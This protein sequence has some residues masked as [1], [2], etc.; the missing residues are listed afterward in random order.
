MVVHSDETS[1]R[2]GE[3]RGQIWVTRL[4]E[5]AYHQD[6]IDIRYRG[7]TE[8]MFWGCYTSEM[9]GPSFMFT[10]ESAPERHH[11]QEDLNSRNSEY[12]VQQQI[13]QEHFLAEQARKPPSRRL[14]RVPKPEGVLLE[15]NKN[16]KGGIDWYRYQTYILLP[17]LIPFIHEVIAKYGE[18]FLVQDGAPSHNAWQQKEL[19]EIP[20]LTVLP[21]PANSP[22]LNQIEPCW[23]YLKRKVSKRPYAPKTKESTIEAWD[24]EWQNLDMERVGQWC[25]KLCNRMERVKDQQGDNKFHG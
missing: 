9:R 6:C 14:K 25:G 12:L 11:A 13:I 22:D 5:E 24:D 21:W 16:A 19:L 3:S 8:M 2:V 23:Y 1:I 7:Y 17:R 10:K 18:C 20:H 4:F 15:R